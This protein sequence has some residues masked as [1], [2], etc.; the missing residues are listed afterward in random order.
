MADALAAMTPEQLAQTPAAMPPPGV[1]PDFTDPYTAAPVLISVST[2]LM[3]IMFMLA[4]LRFYVKIALR[5]TLTPDDCK[6]SI[7]VPHTRQ[8]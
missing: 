8:H 6:H 4:G 2:V 1:T 7:F 3:A 5:H